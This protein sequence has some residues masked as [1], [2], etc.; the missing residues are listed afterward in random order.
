M[1]DCRCR[2]IGLPRTVDA[3]DCRN[4]I[5]RFYYECNNRIIS[6][7]SL[8][9]RYRSNN[10]WT[11]PIVIRAP[12]GGGVHGALYHSQSDE[13]FGDTPGLKKLSCHQLH[14]DVKGLLKQRSCSEIRFYSSS[15]NV[16]TD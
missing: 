15:I 9:S 8:K 2:G 7:A 5:C 6:E 3:T 14:T 12:Y 16:P 1:S 11:C 4:A 10:D 13:W